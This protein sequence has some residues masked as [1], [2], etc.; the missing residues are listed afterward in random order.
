MAKPRR[1]LA[2]RK[3]AAMAKRASAKAQKTRAAK[4]AAAVKA[5]RDA[6]PAREAEV[7]EIVPVDGEI[8]PPVEEAAE[9]T[10]RWMTR[11]PSATAFQAARVKYRLAHPIHPCALGPNSDSVGPFSD[12]ALIA[13]VSIIF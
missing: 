8:S 13:T 6:E 11:R 2:V 9:S 10:P 7:D 5:V 1:K 12:K 4:D 3:A